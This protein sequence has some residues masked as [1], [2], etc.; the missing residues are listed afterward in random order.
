MARSTP[1]SVK[2]GTTS[3][4]RAGGGIGF[5]RSR[6][7][8][9]ERAGVTRTGRG[10]ATW[11]SGI[12]DGT[13][14]LRPRELA[15]RGTADR[16]GAFRAGLV[17]RARLTAGLAFACLETL[18]DTFAAGLRWARLDL[19]AFVLCTVRRFRDDGFTDRVALLFKRPAFTPPP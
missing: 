9:I 16:F 19:W 12:G 5:R 8:G 6:A 10:G 4:P 15:V 11:R 13:G 17:A 14:S 7:G 18:V 1:A 2:S 3:G